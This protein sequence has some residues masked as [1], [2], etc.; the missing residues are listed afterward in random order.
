MSSDKQFD[1]SKLC[2]I[3]PQFTNRET[4]IKNSD[5]FLEKNI[6]PVQCI[7]SIGSDFGILDPDPKK[8]SGPRIRIQ[9]AKYQPKLLK[10]LSYS[11]TSNLNYL[12]KGIIKIS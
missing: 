10:T 1:G 6:R 4:K 12:K 2:S 11:L 9:G 7:G 5:V 8:Y 3:H